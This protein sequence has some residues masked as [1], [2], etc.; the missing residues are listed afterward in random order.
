MDME[1]GM[2]FDSDLE[3]CSTG[4]MTGDPC[5]IARCFSFYRYAP[6]S[7]SLGVADSL[8][9][10]AV[11]SCS[12]GPRSQS[13]LRT[14][15]PSLIPTSSMSCQLSDPPRTLTKMS[16]MGPSLAGQ[17]HAKYVKTTSENVNGYG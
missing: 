5:W 8:T 16:H 4:G 12:A 15:Q 17:T 6:I 2:D 9:P 3:H 11:G 10:V 14:T 7:R 13:G 1:D